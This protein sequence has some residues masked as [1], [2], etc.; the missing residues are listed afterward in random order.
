M[1]D[2]EYGAMFRVEETHWWYVTL[3]DLVIRYVAD[4]QKRKGS[5]EILD[6]GCGTGRLCTLLERYGSVRGCD[7]SELALGFCAA[8]KLTSVFSADLNEADLGTGRYGLITSMDVLYHQW[9]KDDG[10]VLE[11]F[12]R[13]LAPGGLLLLNLPAWE[14]LR[15]THDIAVQ[16]RKRYTKEGLV[17]LL[18]QTGFVVEKASYRLGFLFVPIACWR[19]AA[20]LLHKVRG[21]SEANSDVRRLFPPANAILTRLGRLEN[22]LIARHS[23]PCGTSVFIAARKPVIEA[24][25]A[26]QCPGIQHKG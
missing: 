26:H 18:A 20:R 1:N 5:L 10:A 6:A 2:R 14:F 3:H 16:T 21:V 17:A 12:F 4:E 19:L 7:A 9:V 25:P 15:S 22:R 24:P 11:K 13:A 8:R 23:V